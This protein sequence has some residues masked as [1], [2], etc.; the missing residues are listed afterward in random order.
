MLAY[1]FPG[2]VFS[3]FVLSTYCCF[4]T[5][6][7]ARDAL[8]FMLLCDLCFPVWFICLSLHS[9]KVLLGQGFQAVCAT[10]L[11]RMALF[12]WSPHPALTRT[13]DWGERQT[14]SVIWHR[15]NGCQRRQQRDSNPLRLCSEASSLPLRYCSTAS[16]SDVIKSAIFQV[17]TSNPKL[18]KVRTSNLNSAKAY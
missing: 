4:L 17:R 15:G 9:S 3:I 2:G 5:A 6:S 16:I 8:P 12:F 18:A 11:Y 14:P 7:F 10:N 1:L 13:R